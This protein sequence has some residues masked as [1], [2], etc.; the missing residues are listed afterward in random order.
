MSHN[1]FEHYALLGLKPGAGWR[2]LRSAYRKQVRAWHPD[3]FEGDAEARGRAEERTKAINHAYRELTL[4]YREHAALPLTRGNSE[5]PRSADPAPAPSPDPS[6]VDSGFT[7]PPSWHV[8]PSVR[9][10]AALLGAITVILLLLKILSPRNEPPP[11]LSTAATPSAPTVA[12][13][14][15]SPTHK[16]SFVTYGSTMGEVYAIQGI[17]SRTEPDVWHYGASK[18]YFRNGAVLR[19]EEDREHPLKTHIDV[20]TSLIQATVF[21]KGSTKGEVRS[22]QGHPIRESDKM[23]DYGVSRVYFQGDRVVDWYES[24]LDPL[25]VKH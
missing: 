25:K 18:I 9:Y 6:D 17:P 12:D 24:P 22:I 20:N 4:Y 3:R 19:W 16:E 11:T 23:W 15:S 7:P 1:F 2:E 14:G 13:N 21:G 5:S 10:G 8:V